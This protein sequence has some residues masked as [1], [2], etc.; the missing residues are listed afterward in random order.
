MSR[1]QRR[2]AEPWGPIDPMVGVVMCTVFEAEEARREGLRFLARLIARRIL[3]ERLAQEKATGQT[4]VP[5]DGG[6][7]RPA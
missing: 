2:R 1:H 7:G 6:D 3:A 4:M 5:A